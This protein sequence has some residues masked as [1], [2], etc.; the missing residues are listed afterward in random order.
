MKKLLFLFGF[1]ALLASQAPAAWGQGKGFETIYDHIEVTYNQDGFVDELRTKNRWPFSVKEYVSFLKDTLILI[2]NNPKAFQKE[3]NTFAKVKDTDGKEV[4]LPVLGESALEELAKLDVEAIF[5]DAKFVKLIDEFEYELQTSIL[6]PY[7]IAKPGDSKFWFTL[8]GPEKLLK[9]FIDLAWSF[10]DSVPGAAVAQWIFN[11][12]LGYVEDRQN[13]YQQMTLHYLDA[14]SDDDLGFPLDDAARIR[15]SIYEA[16]ISWWK[17]W[18][19]QEAQDNWLTYGNEHFAKDVRK[20]EENLQ[21]NM[22]QFEQV[23]GSLDWAF[24]ATSTGEKRYIHHKIVETGFLDN[25]LA[26]AY[27]F[28]E[29]KKLLRMRVLLDLLHIGLRFV[30]A[31]GPIKSL[32]DKLINTRYRPQINMEGALYGYFDSTGHAEAAERTAIQSI[33][34]FLIKDLMGRNM[35]V[36]MFQ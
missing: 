19:S 24:V 1:L 11:R 13:F 8:A 23:L 12:V 16:R 25:T 31:P 14:Y 3:M 9:K 36:Q 4:D 7:V 34:P 18:E 17:F 2:K 33:N 15:S 22:D 21:D 26:L 29:P 27:D 20:G 10:L 5:G 35:S 28:Q 6:Y 30:P 32:V